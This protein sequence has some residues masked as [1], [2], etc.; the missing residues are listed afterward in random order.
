VSGCHYEYDHLSWAIICKSLKKEVFYISQN[1]LVRYGVDERCV[2]EII[3]KQVRLD[4]KSKSKKKNTDECIDEIA[5]LYVKIVKEIEEFELGAAQ[6]VKEAEE[7]E[8]AETQAYLERLKTMRTTKQSALESIDSTYIFGAEIDDGDFILPD[9]DD[10]FVASE[11]TPD[12]S[13]DG[14]VFGEEDEEVKREKPY[15]LVDLT[16]PEPE[17]EDESPV[18]FGETEDDDTE[19]PVVPESFEDSEV[20]DLDDETDDIESEIG[21]FVSDELDSV[22]G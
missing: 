8:R 6:R 14:I 1:D 3:G 16:L 13:T 21:E 19:P 10:E 9:I 17:E 18:V 11:P 2:Y 15:Q 12:G 7:K 5:A 4:N 20:A 22:K